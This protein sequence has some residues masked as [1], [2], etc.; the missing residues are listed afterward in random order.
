ME[1]W[2]LLDGIAL[3]S[4]HVAPRNVKLSTLV[5]TNLA[6]TCLPFCDWATVSACVA[7][8]P[9]AFDGFVQFAFADV[10]IQNF[11]QG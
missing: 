10:L 8:Q 6:N 3:H 2:F 9:I 5:V 7:T 1:K 11:A 4:A